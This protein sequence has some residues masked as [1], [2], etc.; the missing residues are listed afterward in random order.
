[1]K[2]RFPHLPPAPAPGK[3]ALHSSDHASTRTSTVPHPTARLSPGAARPPHLL[4]A[5]RTTRVPLAGCH[6]P[7]LSGPT[8]HLVVDHRVLA[9]LAQP[10]PG[11]TQ[12]AP[13]GCSPSPHLLQEPLAQTRGW[14]PVSAGAVPLPLAPP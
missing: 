13:A 4:L 2:P 9:P 11:S 10:T 5:L 14:S 8:T 3:F 12:H 7:A 1:M 6:V